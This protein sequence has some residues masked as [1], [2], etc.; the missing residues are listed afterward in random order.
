MSDIALLSL[1]GDRVAAPAPDPLLSA[2]ARS[3]FSIY[4]QSILGELNPGSGQVRRRNKSIFK[5]YLQSYGRL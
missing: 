3:S 1:D 5:V 4:V 2:K